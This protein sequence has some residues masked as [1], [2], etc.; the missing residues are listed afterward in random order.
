VWIALFGRSEAH[1]I[2]G[3]TRQFWSYDMHI[4]RNRRAILDVARSRFPIQF[5]PLVRLLRS[6]SGAGFL[7]TDPLS[8]GQHHWPDVY[9]EGEG[10]D[11]DFC[12]RCVYH[13]L[14]ELSTYSQVIPVSACTG[15]H[16]VFEKVHERYGGAN[17]SL[18]LTYV[19]LRPVKLPGGSTLP[20]KSSGKLLSDEDK[21]FIVVAWMHE[22]S[23]WK[24]IL[25]VLTEYVN[26]RRI[27][28]ASGHHHQDVSFA[29]R[30]AAQTITLKMEDIGMEM[31]PTGDEGAV[32]DAL[33]L[34]RGVIQG[35][36]LLA[37]EL[38]SSLESGDHVVAHTMVEASPPDLVQLTTM[39][40]EEALSRGGPTVARAHA[41]DSTK[42][43]LITSAMGVLSA[44]LDLPG[45][46]DRVWLYMRSTAALFGSDR[47]SGFASVALEAERVTGTY[48]MT[49]AL[50][51]LV[52]KLFVEASA[53]TLY[54]QMH[55]ASL[56]RVKEEVLIRAARFVHSEIWV[57]HLGWKYAQL[58]DRF[59]IGH[60]VTAFFA[61][62]MAHVTPPGRTTGA[63]S[64]PFVALCQA[65]ADA[66][67]YKATTSTV[68]PLVSAI[69]G[70]GSLLKM[71][72]G[73]RRYGDCG[74][75]RQLLKSHLT[76]TRLV[77]NYKHR[78]PVSNKLSLLEQALCARVTGGATSLDTRSK[79]D[80]IDV[81]AGYAKSRFVGD[82]V[83]HEAVRTLYS[84]CSSLS[85]CQPSPPTIIGHLSDPEATVASLVRIVQ[86]PYDELSLRIAVW[87]F[88][89]LAIH[90]EPALA[91]LFVTGQSRIPADL[92]GKGKETDEKATPGSVSK[93]LRSS[94]LEVAKTMLGTWKTLWDHNPPLLASVLK[95]LDVVWQHGLEHKAALE[96]TRSDATFWTE[97]SDIVNTELGSAPDYHAVSLEDVDGVRRADSHQ[98]VSNHAYR[99][100]AKSFALHLIGLD[101]E[102]QLQGQP[103]TKAVSKPLSFSILEPTFKTESKLTALTTEAVPNSY[104]PSLHDNFVD[105][106]STGFPPLSLDQL[107]SQEPTI[108]RDFGD[109][110]TFSTAL[111]QTRLSLFQTGNGE[112]DQLDVVDKQ[113][114]SIN[115]NLSL[116]HPQ[117]ALVESWQFLLRKAVPFVRKDAAVRHVALSIAATL[118]SDIARE[119]RSGD[120]VATIHG[121]RLSLLLSLL[122]VAWFSAS[123]QVKEVKSFISLVDN[124][125]GIILNE[126]QPPSKSVLGMVTN[127]FH[128][129]LLQIMFFCAK[130]CRNLARRPNVLSAEQRLT[131]ATM[132]EVNLTFTVDALRVVFDSA[133]TRVDVELDRD[134]QFLVAVFDQCTRP[135][136][137]SSSSFWLARCIETDV[138]K[139]SLSLFVST[140]LVG[141]SDLPLLLSRKQ[142]LYAPHVLMFHMSL[143]S[144]P[145]A[146]ERL[147]GEGVLTAY[148]DN[149]LSTAIKAGMIDVTLPEFPGDRSPAHRA[150]CSMLAIVAGVIGALGRHNHYFDT[151]ASGFVHLYGD[152]ISRALSWTVGETITLPLV[153]EIQQVVNVFA[154]IANSAPTT[155]KADPTMTKVLRVFTARALLLLQQL[156][157]ALTHP[158]HLA[159]LLEPVTAEERMQAE[160]SSREQDVLKRILVIRL[161]DQL[162]QLSSAILSALVTISRA[163]NVLIEPQEDWPSNEALLIPVHYSVS[164]R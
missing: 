7:D 102:L 35:N 125:H 39:I 25:E 27:Y 68:N 40:L 113:L 30:G 130:H 110:Y 6:L 133:R 78:S 2:R 70:G 120:M 87:N 129:T 134:M 153:E 76:L 61:D 72:H 59:V 24:V 44:L 121:G 143:S 132:L 28:S 84:L 63:E 9:E 151:E 157:Y 31:D 89:S 51:R 36:S 47:S 81:V 150:Y 156:N 141:L 38:L 50:L 107:E 75:L 88:I 93:S 148:S 34:V 56:Q 46:S 98:A 52:Q 92:K 161:V 80:P 66:F 37:S 64:Q 15:A 99:T 109:D 164:G 74:K 29:R 14:A 95:F 124:V 140:D 32:T 42:T 106:I 135:D 111:L 23:G 159:S 146:A 18:G 104:D 13:Y 22:H 53:S 128:R 122:E 117:A 116:S 103:A 85:L 67:L 112:S 69:A 105:Y 48:T 163:D 138:I 43:Q 155:A 41:Q 79:V 60:L 17:G 20:V 147:A 127:P 142:P 160:S 91:S 136:I 114:R 101:I 149:V 82:L 115:L 100:A 96:P 19:N 77:L 97:L 58:A 145:A 45:Y 118:S 54:V 62:I 144:I 137:G 5:R 152:Q 131:I 57:E 139:S 73:S 158:N 108:E 126:V 65:V 16:A 12:G 1:I 11:R 94:A 33:D 4:G 71:L 49:L 86:H 90:K 83:R 10:G 3:I 162:F 26:R 123:D 21:D 119:A 154:A 8:S 55:A